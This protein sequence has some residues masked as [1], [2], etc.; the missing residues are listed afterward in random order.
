MKVNALKKLIREEVRSVIRE[1]L[2]KFKMNEV[3][4]EPKTELTSLSEAVRPVKRMVKPEVT[5]QY[6]KN[7]KLNEILNQT[8]GGIQGGGDG[9]SNIVE[10]DDSEYPT[11][12]GKAMTTSN[13]G[14]MMNGGMPNQNHQNA[15]QVAHLPEDNAV[16]KSLTRNYGD[17]IGRD[18]RGLM[19][20][21]EKKKGG[22]PLK[23]GR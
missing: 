13:Y 8:V 17:V 22:Q 16:K 12:G 19:K 7:S 11:M 18:Y 20:A 9:I 14:A 2:A 1:E 21:I 15:Q 5:K 23:G 3:L 10:G 4:T 6:T